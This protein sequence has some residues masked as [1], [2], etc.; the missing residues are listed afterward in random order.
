MSSTG[1]I[2]MTHKNVGYPDFGF[3]DQL[4]FDIRDEQM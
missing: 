3:E 4:N 1:T 2:E